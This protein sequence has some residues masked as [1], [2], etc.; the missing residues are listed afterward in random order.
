MVESE[1]CTLLSENEIFKTRE[2]LN[3]K[4]SC[5]KEFQTALARFKHY[6]KTKC[7]VC[8]GHHLDSKYV[9]DYLKQYNAELLSE[10]INTSQK[11][12]I[13]CECGEVFQITFKKIRTKNKVK[14]NKCTIGR[15]NPYHLT[16][17]EVDNVLAN[18]QLTRLSEYV[19]SSQKIK[20][21]C[22]CWK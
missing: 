20:V 2:I 7:D 17:S 12:D 10:Y 9:S 13:R 4:C 8:S 15:K 3:W 18:S 6:G 19:N 21:R 5:G 14:C 1:G 22:R 11:L 16:V